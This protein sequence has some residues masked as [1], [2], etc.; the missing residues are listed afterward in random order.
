[1]N[2]LRVLVRGFSEDFKHHVQGFVSSFVLA[3][4]SNRC[5]SQGRGRRFAR[6]SVCRAFL[7]DWPAAPPA[8]HDS[9]KLSASAM[10]AFIHFPLMMPSAVASFL[11]PPPGFDTWHWNKF[12][13]ESPR[14]NI[15]HKKLGAYCIQ[16]LLVISKSGADRLPQ[17]GPRTLWPHAVRRLDAFVRRHEHFVR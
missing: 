5:N 15:S 16:C 12:L 6:S 17:R 9:R 1:L 13:A 3:V 7:V 4:L 11:L 2:L 14:L 10:H 8:S